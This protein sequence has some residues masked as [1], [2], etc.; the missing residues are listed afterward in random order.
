[1]LFPFTRCSKRKAAEGVCSQSANEMWFW[2]E[3]SQLKKG[4]DV[5]GINQCDLPSSR[6]N[7]VLLGEERCPELAAL[8]TFI[9]WITK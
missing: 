5:W 8:D 6:R 1:M 9:R 3:A 2:V 4:E 7:V